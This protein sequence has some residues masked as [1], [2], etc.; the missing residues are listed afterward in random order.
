MT[1]VH[2]IQSH[3]LEL[4]SLLCNGLQQWLVL[5]HT[6]HTGL[7]S[8]CTLVHVYK[9]QRTISICMIYARAY[10]RHTQ[11]AHSVC[12]TKPL[13]LTERLGTI[14]GTMQVNVSTMYICLMS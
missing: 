8:Y 13:A 2:G 1:L 7:Q 4:E 9:L 11:H 12:L 10:Y 14:L 3:D 6:C 5:V